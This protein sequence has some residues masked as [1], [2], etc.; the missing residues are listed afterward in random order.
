VKSGFPLFGKEGPGEIF[1]VTDGFMSP[2]KSP[3][4]PLLSKGEIF[5]RTSTSLIATQLPQVG[6]RNL[7]C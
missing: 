2:K 5:A 3:L 1:A 7:A 4:I 6:K